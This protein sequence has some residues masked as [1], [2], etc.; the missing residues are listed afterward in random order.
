MD[1]HK[2]IG[3]IPF[4]PKKCA[5]CYVLPRHKFTGPFKP[6]HLQLDERDKPK[7][8]NEPYNAVGT[9]SMRYDICYRDNPSG[10]SECDRKMLAELKTL[11]PKSRR[12]AV[13]RQLVR[14]II[15][16]KRK[17]GM[18]AA[19][20]SQLADKLHK[21][22][23]RRFEKRHVFAKQIDDIWAA[24]LV[25]M[26]SFSR[27]NKGYKF[28]VT[29]IDVYSKHGWIVPLKNKTGKEVASAL[30]KLFKIAV[31]SRLWTDTWTE[32]YNQHVR[33]VLEANNGTLYSTENEEKSSVAERWNRIMK[34]IMWK[35]FTANNTNK[36]I[37]EL[38][39]MVDKYNTTYHRSI[40]LTPSEARDPSNYKHVFRAL[41]G[42]IRSTLPPAKFH[43][44]EKVRI[45]RK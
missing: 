29:V 8:G 21:P 37:D 36:Y 42:K 43:V 4:K 30:V 22:V 5:M 17:L 16:L 35:Y 19:W 7:P 1:I 24:D 26:S 18:G 28:L 3:E 15:G 40:K 38:Q 11:V 44:G 34:R 32:F 20:S 9:T 45:R 6:L 33:R 25:N 13:D 2:V 31:P 27:S 41:Y 23:R 12:E 10:K 14:N 39:N